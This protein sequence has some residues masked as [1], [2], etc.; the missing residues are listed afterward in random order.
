MKDNDMQFFDWVELGLY[1]IVTVCTV[2][3]IVY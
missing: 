1:V 2:G 3:L